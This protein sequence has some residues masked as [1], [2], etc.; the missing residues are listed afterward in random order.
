MSSSTHC[1]EMLKIYFSFGLTRMHM[2]RDQ[3]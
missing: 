3:E 2:N 1:L